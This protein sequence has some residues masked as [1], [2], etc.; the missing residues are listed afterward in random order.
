MGRAVIST[1]IGC[2]GQ[3][4][5][6]GEHLLTADQPAEFAAQTLRLL[7]DHELRRA[8]VAKARQAVAAQYDWD[9]I[10]NRLMAIYTEAASCP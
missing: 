2:E 9:Q 10:A 4:L 3:S 1:T 5:V 8:I 7:R 6:D